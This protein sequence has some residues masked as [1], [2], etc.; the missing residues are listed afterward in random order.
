[1]ALL[2]SIKNLEYAK[3]NNAS[4]SHYKKEVRFLIH[5]GPLEIDTSAATNPGIIF[6]TCV[7]PVS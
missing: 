2:R 7:D 4:C 1:M 6:V 3:T 5:S